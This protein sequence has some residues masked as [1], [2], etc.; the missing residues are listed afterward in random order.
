M[1]FNKG[2]TSYEA[3]DSSYPGGFPAFEKDFIT[4]SSK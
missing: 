4:Y 1:T 2:K 3:L